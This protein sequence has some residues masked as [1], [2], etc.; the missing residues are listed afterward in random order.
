[1]DLNRRIIRVLCGTIAFL[2]VA[3]AIAI[4]LDGVLTL[5]SGG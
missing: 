5:V 2:I 1:M 3:T 4:G